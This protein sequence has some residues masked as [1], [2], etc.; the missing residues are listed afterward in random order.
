M[1]WSPSGKVRFNNIGGYFD[2][3]SYDKDTNDKLYNALNYL[4]S[5]AL[6]DEKYKTNDTDP[7]ANKNFKK[8]FEERKNHQTLSKIFKRKRIIRISWSA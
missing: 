3:P 5:L 1:G 4:I 2:F 7:F 6:K 8:N